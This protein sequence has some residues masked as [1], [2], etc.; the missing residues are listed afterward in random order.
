MITQYG[1]DI[2][3][4]GTFDQPITLP[5]PFL[6][7]NIHNVK[8]SHIESASRKSQ[9]TPGQLGDIQTAEPMSTNFIFNPFMV[10]CNNYETT[11]NCDVIYRRATSIFFKKQ[12]PN[13]LPRAVHNH[14][15]YLAPDGTLESTLLQ[16]AP[17]VIHLKF[18]NMR[19]SVHHTKICPQIISVTS[20]TGCHS[21]QLAAKI[22]L[23][24]KS[25]C[26][27]GP[28]SVSFNDLPLSTRSVHLSTDVSDVTIH[29]VTSSPCHEERVCLSYNELRSCEP[30]S[31]CLD[32]PTIRLTQRNVSS[33]RSVALL[34][35]SGLFDSFVSPVQYLGSVIKT[36]LYLLLGC[37]AAFFFL[38]LLIT[39]L[40]ISKSAVVQKS[41]WTLA[42]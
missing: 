37:L 27:S 41:R 19:I 2:N 38:S 22:V 10:Q 21:W 18:K 11:I 31:F 9:P 14:H 25:L 8:D 29:F 1:I 5:S 6:V 16:S 17:V 40:I 28:A 34:H 20:V 39:L 15:F 33:A 32:D 12:K 7:Q 13:I 3:V 30:I 4:I 42:E 36:G 23:R 26:S 24:A 35:S